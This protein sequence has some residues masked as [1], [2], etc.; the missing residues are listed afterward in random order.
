LAG[1]KSFEKFIP[2]IYFT[3]SI[4]QRL[5]L[6]RGLMD[7]DGFADEQQVGFGTSSEALIDDLRRLVW[8]LGGTATKRSR[9][10]VEGY[11][12]QYKSSIVMPVDLNPFHL[13]RK[14]IHGNRRS[15]VRYLRE[16][17]CSDP[18]ES[19]CIRVNSEDHLYVTKDYI[20]THNTGNGLPL[21]QVI[22]GWAV[23]NPKLNK[24]LEMIEG[25]NFSGKVLFEL[26]ESI[27]V[28][29]HRQN[30]I[31]EAGI[32][33]KVLEC[34]TDV[35]RDLVDQRRLVLPY[36]EEIILEFSGENYALDKS[37]MD[38]YGRSKRVSK[39]SFHTLDAARM[40]ALGWQ[41]FY[42]KKDLERKLRRPTGA[43]GV[44]FL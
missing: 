23:D 35:L 3:G 38:M 15:P 13:D 4:D 20:L 31:D 29:L 39:G 42:F 1:K 24:R 21:L 41:Q 27:E 9:I 19:V 34:S 6:L 40:A 25:F 26:D 18:E 11:R 10:P 30:L 8:S 5:Q 16:I 17:R 36:D 7:T 32:E 33:K 44:I 37:T 14:A 43:T 12:R 28:D 2:E 22:Q